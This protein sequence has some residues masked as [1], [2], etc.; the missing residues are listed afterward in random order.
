[1]LVG[2]AVALASAQLSRVLWMATKREGRPM[3]VV[4]A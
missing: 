3:L 2:G 1:L 4:I